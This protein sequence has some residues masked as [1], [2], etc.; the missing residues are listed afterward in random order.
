MVLLVALFAVNTQAQ[1]NIPGA[2]GS[3]GALVISS[4]TVIDLSQA[5][6]AAWDANNSANAGK[7]VYDSNKWAVVFKYSSV[8]IASNTTVTFSNHPSRGPVVWL[9]SGNVSING[10]L[11][12]NGHDYVAAPNLPEP[13]PG[14]FRGGSGYFA[15]SVNAS[16]GFGPG[17]GQYWYRPGT[18]GATAQD[19]PT[20]YGNPSLIP[21][22]GGSGGAGRQDSNWR[23]SGG[24]GGGAILIAATG[25]LS[26]GG[27]IHANGGYGAE[28][29]GSGGGIRLVSDSLSGNG[30]VNCLGGSAASRAGGL[31]RIRIERV[32][33]TSSIQI[34]PDP[35][36]VPLQ[37]SAAPVIWLPSDGP[38]VRVVSI[39]AV[40]PPSDPRAEF[41][42]V[43]A[44]VTLPLTSFIPVVVETTNA[45]SASTVLIRVSPRAGIP[46]GGFYNE[47]TAGL[48]QVISTNPLV[49]RW[50]N[51]LPV[52]NGY[53]V[54]QARLIRP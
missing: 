33:N 2:D 28:A 10:T 31:G 11:D 34:S 36:V 14:G 21:L 50:T 53:S 43:G 32:V 44:D 20:T 19:N 35:S 17:G 46:D 27:A 38:T 24:A 40:T 26:V 3:D 30:I 23:A 29:G 8:N 7:G 37:A 5:V 49:I 22:I 39:G 48:Q 54:V 51:N 9:V 18:Y 15:P 16:A 25:S 6:T 41:G 47:A 12:L 42:T 45:E 4:N 13:G 1:L 52:G